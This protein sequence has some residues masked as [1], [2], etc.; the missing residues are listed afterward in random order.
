MC[1][2]METMGM[3]YVIPAAEC[4]LQLTLT[5]KGYIS[6]AS[7]LGVVSGS[8]LWGFLADT[9]GRKKMILI[10][11]TV[12]FIMTLISSVVPEDWVF[13]LLRYFNGL[14]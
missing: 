13:M 9:R 12:S 14:L 10:N 4:D 6:A 2:I 11:L 7:F 1:V 5:M 3:M 8:H